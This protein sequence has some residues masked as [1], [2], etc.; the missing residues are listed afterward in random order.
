MKYWEMI[1]DKLARDGWNTT[2]GK[3]LWTGLA[4]RSCAAVS[5]QPGR[6]S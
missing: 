1:A 3:S 2:E 5:L 4:T 6:F